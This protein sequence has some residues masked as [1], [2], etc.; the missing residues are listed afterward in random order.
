MALSQTGRMGKLFAPLPDD[1][2]CLVEMTAFEG[3]SE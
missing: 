3:L 2:L 1:T